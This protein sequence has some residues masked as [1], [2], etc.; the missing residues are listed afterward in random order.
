LWN[1]SNSTLVLHGASLTGRG[2]SNAYGAY[3]TSDG[4]VLQAVGVA[5]LGEN[6]NAGSFGLFNSEMGAATLVGG[7]FTGRGLGNPRG[8]VNVDGGSTLDAENVTVLAE[9]GVTVNHGLNIA[10]GSATTLRGGS[11]TGRGGTTARGIYINGSGTTLDAEKITALGENS[12]MFNHGLYNLGG[13]TSDVTQSVLIGTSGSV[14][15]E[16]GSTTTLSNS[17]LVGAVDHPDVICVL[18]TSG[19]GA[20]SVS[21]DGAT[22]PPLP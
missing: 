5:A 10:D 9:G 1:I 7:S 20:G 3:N 14:H 8:I 13:A 19:T 22:C 2:G 6:G 11:F 18:V 17:R 12:N 21:T 16:A 4:T 15:H